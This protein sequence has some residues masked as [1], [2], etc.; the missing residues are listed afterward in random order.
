MSIKFRPF[1]LLTSLSALLLGLFLAAAYIP[2]LLKGGIILDDWGDI[3]QTLH[4]TGFFECY[5]SWFPLFS[6]RPLAPLPITAT[7][8]LFGLN[9]SWY[10]IVN[11]A[12]Y[13]GA[14]FITAKTIKAFLSPFATAFF[15]S[16]SSL[17]IIAMPIVVSPI[18]Q[19]TATKKSSFWYS[20]KTSQYWNRC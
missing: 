7:T 19:S 18:N 2:L 9:T 8:L 14:L 13:L 3:A 12:L 4:C 1:K 11:T 17:P 6:N 16:L 15:I 5:G 20:S 10:L